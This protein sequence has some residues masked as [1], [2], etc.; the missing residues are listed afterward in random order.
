M[1]RIWQAFALISALVVLGAGGA[2]A[3]DSQSSSDDILQRAINAPSADSWSAYGRQRSSVIRSQGVV[4]ER[5]FR[6]RVSQAGANAWEVGA[7]AA[8]T[9]QINQGDVIL[10]A[11]WARVEAPPDGEDTGVIS[12]ARLELVAAPYTV[13]FEA[14]ARPTREWK[15]YYASGVASRAFSP[16]EAGVTLHLAGARQTIELGPVFVL[17]FGPNYN[18]ARLPR[19]E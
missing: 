12:S 9:G 7:K 16:G 18:V 11:Y 8:I 5:A 17:N 19:N 15:M 2:L 1:R 13:E 3:Q 4:G 6:V 14:P 10:L